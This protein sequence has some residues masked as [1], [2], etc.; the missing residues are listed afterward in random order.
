MIKKL[1]KRFKI[2]LAFKPEIRVYLYKSMSFRA[3]QG[4]S[5]S[6]SIER[7]AN[8]YIDSKKK[9]GIYL[10]DI[11]VKLQSGATLKDAFKDYI[12]NNELLILSAGEND[13][14]LLASSF[15]D[16]AFM[17]KSQYELNKSFKKVLKSAILKL[18]MIMIYF[19]LMAYL[20]SGIIESLD[21]KPLPWYTES[22]LSFSEHIKSFWW[23]WVLSFIFL[24]I[25]L[26]FLLPR[27][28]G[29]L[30]PFLS[31]FIFPFSAYRLMVS[32]SFLISF[33]SLING[34]SHTD[35]L[36]SIAES[37]DPYLQSYAFQMYGDSMSGMD[38]DVV[39]D[40]SLFEIFLKIN[41]IDVIDSSDNAANIKSLALREM[42]LSA[43]KF[44][45]INRS[46][47]V[48]VFVIMAVSI[49]WSYASLAIP[50]L[51]ML[52]KQLS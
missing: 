6:T 17:C 4:F 19:I 51:E 27:Y 41:L 42:E 31:R 24:V 18:S 40:I 1:L 33:S 2:W 7:Y 20:L 39:Y 14:G 38:S 37:S 29:R 34:R 45:R 52:S 26:T 9:V 5:I 28:V 50:I 13:V 44:E 43:E 15:N 23:V 46:L 3:K 49:F 35:A 30:R 32:S 10:A 47:N 48:V 12:P 21:I 8:A 22:F 11:A 25:L 36:K 16:A